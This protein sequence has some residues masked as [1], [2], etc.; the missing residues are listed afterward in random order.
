MVPI[1]G[2]ASSFLC[3][4]RMLG[5]KNKIERRKR[6]RTQNN[7]PVFTARF[8]TL[9]TD[10][11][12]TT[13]PYPLSF[14]INIYINIILEKWFPLQGERAHSLY[15]WSFQKQNREDRTTTT[16]LSIYPRFTVLYI[17]YSDDPTSGMISYNILHRL[18]YTPPNPILYHTQ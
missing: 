6:R 14:T 3:Y 4:V 16:D 1:T 10:Y 9:S 15:F 12:D 17:K 5:F 7:R 13:S 2:R 8:I 11:K 18:K